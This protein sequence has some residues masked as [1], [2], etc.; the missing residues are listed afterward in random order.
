MY[1]IAAM[2]WAWWFFVGVANG[3]CYLYQNLVV[4]TGPN[5]AVERSPKLQ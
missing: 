4:R 2:L 1:S 5:E 3:I